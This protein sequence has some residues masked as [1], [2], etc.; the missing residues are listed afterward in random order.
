MLTATPMAVYLAY[1]RHSL[2]HVTHGAIPNRQMGH[3]GTALTQNTSSKT[4]ELPFFGRPKRGKSEFRH[5]PLCEMTRKKVKFLDL[6]N[7]QVAEGIVM[8]IDSK[9]IVMGRPIGHVYCEV[10][11]DEAK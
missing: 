10:L 8:S 4:V 1:L 3:L 5:P 9:K 2:A 7:E 11:V 6:E